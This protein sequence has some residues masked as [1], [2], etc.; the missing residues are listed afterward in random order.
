MPKPDP[1]RFGRI[2]V[3]RFNHFKMHKPIHRTPLSYYGGKQR[4]LGHI[5]PNIPDH[6]I[7]T[8]SFC[9]GAAVFWAKA[10][11]EVEVI[12]DLNGAVSI[13]WRQIKTNFPELKRV[14]ECT[15]HSR[16]TYLDAMHIFERPHLHLEVNVAWALW[17]ACIQGFG[18]KPGS[19]GYDLTGTTG[20]KLRNKIEAF[21]PHLAERLHRV[22]VECNDALK[23]IGSRDCE[24]AFHYVDPPYFNSNCGHYEGYSE[25]DFERLL[26]L[27]ASVKGKFLLS[28]YPSEILARFTKENGW[29]QVEIVQNVAVT[30]KRSGQKKKT[31]VLTANYPL[32]KA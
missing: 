1:T 30:G 24:T 15:Q 25:A 4:M 2:R 12:N 19:W 21:G 10:A 22:Q 5:L 17:V 20:R 8:E 3:N 32:V 23:V 29:H 31:E 18:S 9:G 28:S 7:Y 27:L 6:T 13:F 26:V 16:E 11:S 14:I